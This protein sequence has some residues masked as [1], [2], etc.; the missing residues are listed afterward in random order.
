MSC[1]FSSVALG[2][3]RVLEWTAALLPCLG[4]EIY[5]LQVN[6]RHLL[7]ILLMSMSQWMGTVL[8]HASVAQESLPHNLLNSTAILFILFLP[9]PW[10]LS[11]LDLS[12]CGL[13]IIVTGYSSVMVIRPLH[14]LRL[15]YYS[16]ENL[17]LLLHGGVETHC[18][19]VKIRQTDCECI[20]CRINNNW[21]RTFQP[22]RP[23]STAYKTKDTAV[24]W[25][26]LCSKHFDP[27]FIG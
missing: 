14:N 7:V 25:D 27:L 24:S 19:V 26:R 4:D 6:N 22:R 21:W 15:L 11:I 18:Y 1:S 13:W 8:N 5:S 17:I 20:C 10:F 23:L 2:Y 12:G 9:P 16:R 3:Y